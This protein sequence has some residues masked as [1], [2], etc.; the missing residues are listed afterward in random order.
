MAKLP[1]ETLS[2][3]FSLMRQLAEGIEEAS[4]AEWQLFEQYGETSETLGELEE[5]QSARERLTVPYSALHNLLLKVLE[6][7]PVAPNA[8]LELL[9]QTIENGQTAIDVGAASVRDVKR[10]WNLP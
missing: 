2:T 3:I 9:A 8:T 4:A 5:L 7:Q 6:Y 10:S 1:E